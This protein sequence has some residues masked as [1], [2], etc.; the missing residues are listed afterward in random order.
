MT[1]QSR[2]RSS[3]DVQRRSDYKQQVAL[4]GET[5]QQEQ[6]Q[7]EDSTWRPLLEQDKQELA[8]V[9]WNSFKIGQ[10]EDN[11]FIGREN[12]QSEKWSQ[13]LIE[14]LGLSNTKSTGD[15][16]R[17]RSLA[18][19]RVQMLSASSPS[20]PS[21]AN[22]RRQGATPQTRLGQAQKLSNL[23][24]ADG[25]Q[26]A[27]PESA[28]FDVD[29]ARDRRARQLHAADTKPPGKRRAQTIG[30]HCLVDVSRLSP[31]ATRGS[32]TAAGV[33]GSPLGLDNRAALPAGRAEQP[34]P[35][36]TVQADS[37]ASSHER[38]PAKYLRA[39]LGALSPT[40]AGLYKVAQQEQVSIS[41]SGC[42]TR[43][44]QASQLGRPGRSPLSLQR[45]T[46]ARLSR[47]QL[48]IQQQRQEQLVLLALRDRDQLI[49]VSQQKAKPQNRRYASGPRADERASPAL[50]L[51]GAPLA[52]PIDR[53]ACDRS[54]QLAASDAPQRPE[55]A[56]PSVSIVVYKTLNMADQARRLG[57]ADG[58]H[59]CDQ[60]DQR[61]EPQVHQSCMNQEDAQT[62]NSASS[63]VSLNRPFCKI[64]H[65]GANK[66][67]DRLISPCKCSGTM[68]YIHCGC[69]LKWLEISN[70]SNERP[71]CCELC[72]H[73]YTW[74]KR[75]NYDHLRFPKCSIKDIFLH[76]LFV[77]ALAMMLTSATAPVLLRRPG[78]F[79]D[80]TNG[81]HPSRPATASQHLG[82]P[83]SFRATS[84][85][86][87]AHPEAGKLAQDDRF[88]LVC[89]SSFFIFFF[90]AIY[91]QTKAR[92]TLYNLVCKF[93]AINQTYYITE[94]DHVQSGKQQQHLSS[95]TDDSTHRS[96]ANKSCGLFKS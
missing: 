57:A 81:A 2:Y 87:G 30:A 36:P 71:I 37:M 22:W 89:A 14:L 29:G 8:R 63:T 25:S 72:A 79:E 95:P 13:S 67:G 15:P 73:E 41:A 84:A 59:Q 3:S 7:P 21:A 20:L 61:P 43:R 94:Y 28:A 65:L 52:Y 35:T 19:S 88:M 1:G 42:D 10:L 16:Q 26:R 24:R 77:I 31:S 56:G 11:E 70:R 46:N 4:D 64:C 34:S 47:H 17:K 9:R 38:P 60:R 75:F 12:K 68:Q 82:A 51:P 27:D 6:R 45:Q 86:A 90:V 80:T 48:K 76:L 53:A 50:H 78:P 62:I 33:V 96:E 5:N 74:H 49:Q 54:N 32:D 92:E 55:P 23:S 40:Q 18:R 69:L 66:D 58:P 91:V 39:A 93:I 85:N 44:R 83:N